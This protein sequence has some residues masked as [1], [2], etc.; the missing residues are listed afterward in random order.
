MVLHYLARGIKLQY[1]ET[2][3]NSGILNENRLQHIKRA[4]LAEEEKELI[5]KPERDP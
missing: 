2:E 4:E 5:T 3:L 1:D